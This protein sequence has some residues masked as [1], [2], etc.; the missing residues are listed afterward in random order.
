[1]RFKISHEGSKPTVVDVAGP[2]VTIG[3]TGDNDVALNK[4]F[5][6]AHHARIFAGVLVEDLGSR[7][8]TFID[9]ERIKEPTLLRG[10]KFSVGGRSLEVEIQLSEEDGMAASLSTALE[11]MPTTSGAS[12]ASAD[13]SEFLA[14][15]IERDFESMSVPANSSATDVFIY[16]A[17]QFI[18]NTERIISSIA[19]GMTKELSDN[20]ILPDS[21]RNF[22]LHM[23]ELF[24]QS[25]NPETR[26]ELHDFLSRVVH[27][28]Y[29]SIH[30]YQKAS[31]VVTEELKRQLRRGALES[32][33][34]IPAYLRYLGLEKLELWDRAQAR[35]EDWN[36]NEVKEL[37]DEHVTHL[38]RKIRFEDLDGQR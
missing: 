26:A 8:G 4:S 31:F 34:A 6:S 23:A 16:E 21:N 20:T 37:L 2:E 12:K 30:C 17:F 3:R 38:A 36:D 1:M 5:V 11:K 29:A 13:E 32:R 22:R 19:G 33:P 7:N 18:R 28:I 9:G 15:L 35:I 25:R 14:Q 27:W 24:V 10:R